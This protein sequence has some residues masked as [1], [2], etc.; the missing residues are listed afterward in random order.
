MTNIIQAGAQAPN[1]TLNDQNGNAVSL[2]DFKGKKVLLSFHPFAFTSVCTDQMR[3]LDNHVEAFAEKN[4]VVL[5]VS[6]DPEPSKKAWATVISLGELA[7]LSD[8]PQSQVAKAY[9]VYNEELSSS[10]RANILIDET[11]KV[12]WSKNY[13]IPELPDLKEVFAQL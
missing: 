6:V 3:S 12:I 1:F 13:P 9:G 11:G 8:F 2:A 4:T 10:G 7:I 5:G